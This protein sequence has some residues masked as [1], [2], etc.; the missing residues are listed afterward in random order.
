MALLSINTHPIVLRPSS[1]LRIIISNKL[2]HLC[3]PSHNTSRDSLY[4]CKRLV[5]LNSANQQCP[6]HLRQILH[7]LLKLFV[8]T[9]VSNAALNV[10][11]A[12]I[13]L[14]LQFSA[15]CL[16]LMVRRRITTKTRNLCLH[17]LLILQIVHARTSKKQSGRTPN[18]PGFFFVTYVLLPG[19]IVAVGLRI[20]WWQR[21]V[22]RGANVRAPPPPPMWHKNRSARHN[23]RKNRNKL[24][25]QSF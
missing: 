4:V 25:R 3:L 10:R 1:A 23:Q 11:N 8:V 12:N 5:L 6:V 17:I 22:R 9:F 16:Q 24:E 19:E 21:V 20:R 7:V 13:K 2:V 18:T 14:R 15:D